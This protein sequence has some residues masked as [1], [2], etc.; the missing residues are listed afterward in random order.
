MCCLELKSSWTQCT[1]ARVLCNSLE[2]WW[3]CQDFVCERSLALLPDRR[4]PSVCFGSSIFWIEQWMMK[5]PILLDLDS[6]CISA[7]KAQWLM[8]LAKFSVLL[9]EIASSPSAQQDNQMMWSIIQTC[10]LS[11]PISTLVLLQGSNL[12]RAFSQV[13]SGLAFIKGRRGLFQ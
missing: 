13:Q 4:L 12:K 8:E 10:T 1:V 5:Q 9:V 11:R 6:R 7:R 2:N 3:L